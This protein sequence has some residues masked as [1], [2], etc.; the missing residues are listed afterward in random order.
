MPWRIFSASSTPSRADEVSAATANSSP[1]NTRHHALF[2]H[3]LP[4]L[5]RKLG[6]HT[7]AALVA[8]AIVNLLEAVDVE[9][10]HGEQ[11]VFRDRLTFQRFA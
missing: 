6:Q 3:Q 1:T 9:H 4:H 2:T 11:L 5:L 7:I 8:P 10:H